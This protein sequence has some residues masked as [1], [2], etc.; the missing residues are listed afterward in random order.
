ME[1]SIRVR[2]DLQEELTAQTLNLLYQLNCAKKATIAVG[3]GGDKEQNAL[4]KAWETVNWLKVFS[5]AGFFSRPGC[6]VS[7]EHSSELKRLKCGHE[8]CA[9]CVK[10]LIL[11]DTLAITEEFL[12]PMCGVPSP[13]NAYISKEGLES[14]KADYYGS[15]VRKQCWK[16]DIY[17]EN[18]YFR[19]DFCANCH[20]DMCLICY[21]RLFI[22]NSQLCDCGEPFRTYPHKETLQQTLLK[23]TSCN[24]FQSLLLFGAVECQEQEH[25]PCLHCLAGKDTCPVCQR[26]LNSTEK[27]LIEEFAANI[28]K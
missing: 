14:W 10:Q 4:F 18:V 26:P 20:S 11:A 23:C 3:N 5:E 19:E 15:N 13:I 22:S 24:E 21:N 28:G 25:M 7:S 27:R 8:L 17:R 12:C 9:D 6:M 16:C 2:S 1:L